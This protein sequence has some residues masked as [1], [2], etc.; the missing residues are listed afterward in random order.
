MATAGSEEEYAAAHSQLH[1]ACEQHGT[2]TV[3]YYLDGQWLAKQ[4]ECVLLPL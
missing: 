2:M 4:S 1:A 3:W